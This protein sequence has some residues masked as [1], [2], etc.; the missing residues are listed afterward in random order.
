MF[1]TKQHNNNW[2]IRH[3]TA[4]IPDLISAQIL[5]IGDVMLDQ[6]WSGLTERISPEAPIPIVKIK[7]TTFRAGGAANV[8]LNVAAL[9]CRVTLL[10]IIGDDEAA[11]TLQQCLNHDKINAHLIRIPH[12][13]TI[14]KLRVTS[15]K[16]QLLRLD[17]E[18]PIP[19]NLTTALETP[20][21]DALKNTHLVILSDYAKGTLQN[22]PWFIA[23]AKQQG[24]PV[25]VDPKAKDLSIYQGATLLTPNLAEF[26]AMVGHCQ[27]EKSFSIKAQTLREQL[28][29]DALL[30]TRGEHGMTLVEKNT[31]PITLPTKSLDIFD[32]TGAGDT[33]IATMAYALIAGETLYDATRLAN[34][35]ANVV[36]KKW[37]TAT[38]TPEELHSHTDA[39]EPIITQEK[40][41]TLIQAAQSKNQRVVMTNGC[42]DVLH[43][44]HIS[45]LTAAKALGDKLIVAVN[46]DA[47]VQTLKGIN[48]PLN[49]LQTRMEMLAAIHCIDWI[50]PFSELT[51]EKLIHYLSPDILVKGG[52]YQVNDIVG[53][54]HVQSRGGQVRALPFLEGYSTTSFIKKIQTTLKEEI[55]V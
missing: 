7:N 29:L 38:V 15:K 1:H 50:V 26:E 48:R 47:S 55:N 53:G 20:F 33:V 22:A 16:Q 54:A 41:Y 3:V 6:Y 43:P 14:T 31:N 52:D 12:W 40:A 21:L 49:S 44:G 32:V 34:Q 18:D 17:F 24:I 11:H 39:R 23:H 35:A 37:G 51:P 10:G 46:D 4:S 9:G 28:A 25:L 27:D 36:I 30:V 19:P 13:K 2:S 8:A 45:Y 42:F 5:I